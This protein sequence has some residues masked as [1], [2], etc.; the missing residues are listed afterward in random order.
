MATGQSLGHHVAYVPCRPRHFCIADSVVFAAFSVNCGPPSQSNVDFSSCT[1]HTF[2][3]N[4]NPT[5]A[6]GFKG[7]PLA[8]CWDDGSWIYLGSCEPGVPCVRASPNPSGSP[9][10]VEGVM[11]L[12]PHIHI[13]GGRPRLCHLCAR[14]SGD[15]RGHPRT[16]GKH[17]LTS[18][19]VRQTSADIR[20][21]SAD[22]RET[23]A[24]ICGHPVVRGRSP[25]FPLCPVS[26]PWGWGVYA[27]YSESL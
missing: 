4:C 13:S 15:I 19:D 26:F 24:D 23:S 5:C 9:P 2:G 7:Q 16:S 14:T 8:I 25:C 10:A 18:A 20:E 21:T 17:P 27:V 11:K 1:D 6:A 3:G 12:L 22:I